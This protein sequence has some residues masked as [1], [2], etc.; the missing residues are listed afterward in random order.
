MYS[1]TT[2]TPATVSKGGHNPPND[3]DARPVPPQGSDGPAVPEVKR[4]TTDERSIELLTEIAK[5]RC[6]IEHCESLIRQSETTLEQLT[7]KLQVLL[8]TGRK[9][10]F[11]S[12][13]YFI[14]KSDNTGRFLLRTEIPPF[15]ILGQ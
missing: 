10:L 14:E 11:G 5:H 3:S 7:S 2:I 12:K 6:S 4:D 15:K 9:V 13:V 8:G 1:G